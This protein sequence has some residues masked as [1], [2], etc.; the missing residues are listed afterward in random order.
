MCV[1]G[2]LGGAAEVHP[3]DIDILMLFSHQVVSDTL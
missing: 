1:L 2:G 3:G